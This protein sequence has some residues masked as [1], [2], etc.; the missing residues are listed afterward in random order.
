MKWF[1][2]VISLIIKNYFGRL[3]SQLFAVYWWKTFEFCDFNLFRFCLFSTF[4]AY[5][6]HLT[7]LMEISPYKFN[8]PGADPKPDYVHVVSNYSYF[9]DYSWNK[10]TNLDFYIDWRHRA[11]TRIVENSIAS[12]PKSMTSKINMLMKSNRFA[13]KSRTVGKAWLLTLLKA[14]KAV[15]VKLSIQ[16]DTLKMFTGII[17]KSPLHYPWLILIKI[18]SVHRVIRKYGGVCIADEVQVGFGRAGTHYWAFET[19]NV[20]PDIVTIAKP[21]G[22][23]HPVGAV[24]TTQKI[25]DLFTSTG[26]SYFNTVSN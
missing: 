24:V 23:G 7:S 17:K 4:S 6:G 21:M 3:L 19:Q 8:L 9:L 20:V 15:V 2:F 5:H 22:N 18:Q 26:V 13:K 25:A 16:K 12:T 14:C 1:R 11:Q 10:S